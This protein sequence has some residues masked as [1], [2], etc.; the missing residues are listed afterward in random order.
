MEHIRSFLFE[1]EGVGVVEIILILVVKYTPL[2]WVYIACVERKNTELQK[3]KLRVEMCMLCKEETVLIKYYN[4][5]FFLCFKEGIDDFKKDI[6]L[7]W[8]V[9]EK[10]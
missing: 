7:E 3:T 4:V 10:I 9:L 2:F 1:E 5:L 6:L 8:Y